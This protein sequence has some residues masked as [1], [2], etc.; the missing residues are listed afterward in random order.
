MSLQIPEQTGK[1]G[2]TNTDYRFNILIKNGFD[3]LL[4]VEVF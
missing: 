4:F 3:E 1:D 2:T